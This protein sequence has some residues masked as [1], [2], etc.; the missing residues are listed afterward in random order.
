VWSIE[1]EH[2]PAV[3]SDTLRP[4]KK[5]KKAK[6]SPNDPASLALARQRK[7]AASVLLKR[8]QRKSGQ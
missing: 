8:R 1:Q 3:G 2:R 5:R 4:M 6:Q 7:R